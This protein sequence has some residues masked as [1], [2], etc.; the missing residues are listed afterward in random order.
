MCLILRY[1]VA[2]LAIKV[3][4]IATTLIVLRSVRE[5]V[6]SASLR[7]RPAGTHITL[8]YSTGDTRSNLK[9]ALPGSRATHWSPLFKGCCA[10]TQV[11]CQYLA[12]F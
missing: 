4:G 3:Q 11:I 1:E 7:L 5:D 10:Q 9:I 12:T 2:K 8:L 6:A